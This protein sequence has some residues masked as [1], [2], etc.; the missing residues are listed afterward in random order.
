MKK[1]YLAP[2]T[3]VVK[4]GMQQIMTGSPGSIVL[5]QNEEE[6]SDGNDIGSR[7]W[8]GVWDDDEDYD[9]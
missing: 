4:I 5:D 9:D 6:I 2:N 1:I 8:A 3:I 7:R